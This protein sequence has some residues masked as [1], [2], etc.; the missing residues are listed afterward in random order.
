[1]VA[2]VSF[3]LAFERSVFGIESCAQ[4]FASIHRGRLNI[5]W[6][7]SLAFDLRKGRVDFGFHGPVSP[8]RTV[9]KIEARSQDSAG[10]ATERVLISMTRSS[11]SSIGRRRVFKVSTCFN[12]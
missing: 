7:G 4:P 9:K 11:V 5:T 1:M 8:V 3:S 6:V 12:S 2:V 10:L